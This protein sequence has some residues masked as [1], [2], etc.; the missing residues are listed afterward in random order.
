MC[1]DVHVTHAGISELD[2][3]ALAYL[4]NSHLWDSVTYANKSSNAREGDQGAC[5]D[6]ESESRAWLLDTSHHSHDG[7]GVFEVPSESVRRLRCA[8]MGMDPGEFQRWYHAQ[9][10]VR[11]LRNARSRQAK[12]VNVG[13]TGTCAQESHNACAHAEGVEGAPSGWHGACACGQTDRDVHVR[14]T[15]T[16]HAGIGTG[17]EVDGD[18]RNLSRT[19]C[20]R[21]GHVDRVAGR[22]AGDNVFGISGDDHVCSGCVSQAPR[23]GTNQAATTCCMHRCSGV[24]G[25]EVHNI[26]QGTGAAQT[27]NIEQVVKCFAEESCQTTAAYTSVHTATCERSWK[28][29]SEAARPHWFTHD[30]SHAY[31]LAIKQHQATLRQLHVSCCCSVLAASISVTLRRSDGFPALNSLALP[32]TSRAGIRGVMS[33]VEVRLLVHLICFSVSC[34]SLLFICL[35]LLSVCLSLFVHAFMSACMRARMRVNL[36]V[37]CAIM[38]AV[39][40]HLERGF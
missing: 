20:M 27:D 28:G 9:T 7:C 3:M 33:A 14:C 26:R 32:R 13:N 12:C 36:H 15:C 38:V 30:V 8:L 6:S 23:E 35:S 16:S 39:V 5:D 4:Y 21:G 1:F 29:S 2:S 22:S 18:A 17:D 19:T 10:G 40:V 24:H 25:Q 37:L 31:V 11:M 34:L